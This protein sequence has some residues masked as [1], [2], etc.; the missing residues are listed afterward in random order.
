MRVRWGNIKIVTSAR[1]I[2]FK[3][4]SPWRCCRY[5]GV[6]GLGNDDGNVSD[7]ATNQCFDWLNE[8]KL[9]CC[10]CGMLSAENFPRT[11]S[12]DDVKF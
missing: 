11:L 8:E 4:G 2:I 9:S 1:I 10:T 5:Q 6:G 3:S 7:N 12:N